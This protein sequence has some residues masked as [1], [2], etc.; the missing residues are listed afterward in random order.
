MAFYSRLNDT[1]REK[2]EKFVTEVSEHQGHDVTNLWEGDPYMQKE[3]IWITYCET[4]E[5]IIGMSLIPTR[6]VDALLAVEVIRDW[7]LK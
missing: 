1:E 7:V 6:E 5:R 4:C 2:I 3:Y